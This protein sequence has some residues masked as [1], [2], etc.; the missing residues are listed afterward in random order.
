VV[1]ERAARR[2]GAG[3]R[4]AWL[5]AAAA[6]ALLRAT[7][8]CNMVGLAV[9]TQAEVMERAAPVLDEQTDYE[10]A[11][12]AAPAALVQVEGLLRVAPG[13][14][15]LLLL[16]TRGW[17][18]YAYAFVEDEKERAELES[19]LE[20]A[21]LER[22]RARAMYLDAKAFGCRLL[23]QLAPGFDA[24]LG[25][26]PEA[27]ERFL[28]EEF[29]EPSA[30]PAL[31][32]TGYAWGSAIGVSRD[33]PASIADLPLALAL[34]ER[35]VAL[36]ERY[37]HSAGHVFLGVV[38]SS[39]GASA[40]GDPERGKQHFERALELTAH[41]AHMVQLN[42]ARYYAVQAQDRALFTRLLGEVV[43]ATAVAP[44]ELSLPNAVAR[45]RAERL[46]GHVE[47]LILGARLSS[48]RSHASS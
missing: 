29:D 22:A 30:A 8:G 18:S 33:D 23:R 27:L 11:R 44:A 15:R 7:L 6:V 24:A 21:E 17:A 31:F 5:E 3:R 28:A 37:Y 47:R 2:S 26:D 48:R 43:A 45:R 12:V 20:R 19:D 39:R 25:R 14:E 32:W 35:S 4:R 38:H 9:D 36:D 1:T 42:Y 46:L 10:V 41:E 16:A 34:V 13:D 40:G